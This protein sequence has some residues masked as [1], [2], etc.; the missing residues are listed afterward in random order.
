MSQDTAAK[1]QLL[2]TRAAILGILALMGRK[3]QRT[4]LVKLIYLADNTF[5]ESLSRTLTGN[6]YM[7]DHYGPNAVGNAIV[8][9]ADAMVNSGELRMS[10]HTSAYGGDTY[11]Y[12]VDS[13]D[14]V[15]RRVQGDLD[16][17]ESQ[18]L[19]DVVREYGRLNVNSIVKRSKE[20]YPFVGAKQYGL[21]KMQQSRR[22]QEVQRML[23]SNGEFMEEAAIGIR[24]AQAE[25]WGLEE[26]VEA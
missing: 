13:P 25:V 2:K 21:L 4:K 11:E 19:M 9:E 20:T 10:V 12:W 8:G 22:A 6:I 15:W 5:F 7:W 3:T 26:T 23:A 18:I 17:G 24:E 1:K 14:E 16:A